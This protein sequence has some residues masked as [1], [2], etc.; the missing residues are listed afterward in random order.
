MELG[1]IEVPFCP[2]KDNDFELFGLSGVNGQV[3]KPPFL[4]DKCTCTQ[5]GTTWPFTPP[6]GMLGANKCKWPP[7]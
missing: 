2:T 1:S 6:I 3:S 5:M 7:Q 4:T